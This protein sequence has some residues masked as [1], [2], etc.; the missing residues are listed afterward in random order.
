M[1]IDWSLI[2]LNRQRQK[3]KKRPF[4]IS[5]NKRKV[6]LPIEFRLVGQQNSSIE[7]PVEELTDEL[8]F[9]LLGFHKL[10]KM[11]KLFS[12]SLSISKKKPNGFTHRNPSLDIDF[13][14]DRKYKTEHKDCLRCKQLQQRPFHW[15]V[16]SPLVPKNRRS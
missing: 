2:D 1:P 4:F 7:H 13:R 14:V 8:A 15:L 3:I 10:N 11:I 5:K 16:E 6:S 9:V 12:L